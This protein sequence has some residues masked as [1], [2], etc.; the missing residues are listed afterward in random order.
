MHIIRLPGQLQL[1]RESRTFSGE[2]PA[3]WP[4]T[5]DIRDMNQGYLT[6]KKPVSRENRA[7]L[8]K[9]EEKVRNLEEIQKKENYPTRKGGGVRVV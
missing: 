3:T 1:G 5:Q 8:S 4:S 9:L 6:G 7:G 2:G